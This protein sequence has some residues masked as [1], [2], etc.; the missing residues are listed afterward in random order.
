MTLLAVWALIA[1]I[2]ATS[3]LTKAGLVAFAIV[4]GIAVDAGIR[5]RRL[6]ARLDG[7][8]ERLDEQAD[9]INRLVGDGGEAP[10]PTSPE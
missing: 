1:F 7:V 5:A 3:G 2:I 10:K 6:L 9:K 4:L 8:S